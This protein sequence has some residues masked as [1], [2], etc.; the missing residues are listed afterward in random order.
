[1]D[2][3]AARF[4]VH[5]DHLR[6]VAHRML[7]GLGDAEDAVQETWVRYARAEVA[8][9][10]NLGGWLTTVLA[11]VCLDMLRRRT[12]RREHLVEP[13]TGGPDS[14]ASSAI[15]PAQE[16]ALA[17]A[18]GRALLV[19]L[20]TLTPAE[21]IALVLHDAFAVPFD[22]IG[23]MLDRSPEAAKKLAGRAR[24]RVHARPD[25]CTA[26]LA[27]HRR[28]VD[29]FV[30]AVRGGDLVT[31]LEVLDPDVVRHADPAV[32]PVGSPSLLRG[33]AEVAAESQFFATR[34]HEAEPAW[35]NG[36]I[37]LIVAP[38]G[39]LTL[40]LE[41]T[42]EDERIVAYDVVADPARLRGLEVAV[43]G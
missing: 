40:A 3:G 36:A 18:V 12:A 38:R 16:A 41:I 28:V 11:R 30:T 39:R 10:E 29:T 19:V 31:L 14:G 9:V 21:R 4:E 35:V 23:P 5:R 13:S 1:M 2:D 24:R 34:A 7:G 26:D 20:E 22:E 43:L 17:D 25:V 27:R 15:D 6:T 42:V 37:G 8:G 32:L 33:A